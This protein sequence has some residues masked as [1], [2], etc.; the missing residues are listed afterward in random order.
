MP[1]KAACGKPL[2]AAACESQHYGANEG[3]SQREGVILPVMHVVADEH[4]DA[5]S[6]GGGLRQREVHENHAALDNMQPKIYQQPR[7]NE[8]R[9]ER[10]NHERECIHRVVYLFPA[11]TRAMEFTR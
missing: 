3:E 11:S 9:N 7:Q 8:A 2:V 10:P 5:T 6:E 4:G 1:I